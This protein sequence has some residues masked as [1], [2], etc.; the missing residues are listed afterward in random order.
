M[1]LLSIG[2]SG[3][4]G[5]RAIEHAL[6]RCHTV[7]ALVRTTSSLAA[8]PGLT[9]VKGIPLSQPNI[10]A[11]FATPSTPQAVVVSLNSPRQ[12]DKPF[13]NPFAPPR[14][15]AD[16]HANLAKVME[17]HETRRIVSTSAWAMRVL[18]RRSNLCYAYEDH[19][20]VD[21]EMEAKK[22]L[23]WTLARFVMLRDGEVLP[24]M[25]HGDRGEGVGLMASV[26]RRSAAACLL[27]ATE[28]SQWVRRTPVVLN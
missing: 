5:Q 22:N 26:T 24:V 25:D 10:E 15:M 17:K 7:T 3:R 19:E 9:I 20:A 27:D 13:A 4:T 2:G 12:S 16:S 1:R 8:R 23:E 11:A 21:V 6:A 28:G 14:L 18:V